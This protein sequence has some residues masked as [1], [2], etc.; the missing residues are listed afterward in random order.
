MICS[1]CHWRWN[2]HSID[3]KSYCRVAEVIG[4]RRSALSIEVDDNFTTNQQDDR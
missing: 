2:Q 1:F 4:K 3:I